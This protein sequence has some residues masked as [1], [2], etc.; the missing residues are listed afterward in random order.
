MEGAF[1]IINCCIFILFIWQFTRACNRYHYLN[2]VRYH[3]CTLIIFAC[4]FFFYK[5]RSIP[6]IFISLQM[7]MAALLSRKESTKRQNWGTTIQKSKI[8]LQ[9]KQMTEEKLQF[10]LLSGVTLLFA[11]THKNIFVHF[12]VFFVIILVIFFSA[13]FNWHSPKNIRFQQQTITNN[14]KK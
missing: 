12:F 2:A 3:E 6:F 8:Y 9:V 7:A 1:F 11:R 5:Q 4:L 14:T 10:K 13:T